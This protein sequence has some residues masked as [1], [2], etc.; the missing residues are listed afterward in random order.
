MPIEMT[1]IGAQKSLWQKAKEK[2]TKERDG[3]KSQDFEGFCWFW[4]VFF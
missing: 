3:G 4:C 2:K 1:V